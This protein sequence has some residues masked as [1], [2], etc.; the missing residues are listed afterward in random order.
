MTNHPTGGGISRRIHGEERDKIKNQYGLEDVRKS[1]NW[2]DETDL[3]ILTFAGWSS[4]ER[5]QIGVCTKSPC[6]DKSN[7]LETTIY[8]N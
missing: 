8:L 4:P 6:K 7:Q 5:L 3:G 2:N 1:G